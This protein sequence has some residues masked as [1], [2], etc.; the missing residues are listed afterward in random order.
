MQEKKLW[1]ILLLMNFYVSAQTK[2]VV[3]DESGKPIP[4]VNIWVENENIGTTS[5][6]NGEFSINV[7]DNKYLIFSAIGYETQR[8]ISNVLDKIVLTSNAIELNEVIPFLLI[9]IHC[10]KSFVSGDI[11]NLIIKLLSPDHFHSSFIE[12]L[13]P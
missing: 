6:E 5:E 11:D 7:S 2:G 9:T 3:V 12:R 4:Y 10:S 13:M 8:K 1:F